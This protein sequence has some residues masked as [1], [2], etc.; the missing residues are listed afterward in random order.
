MP[1]NDLI[2]YAKWADTPYWLAPSYVKGIDDVDLDRGPLIHNSNYVNPETGV[3]KTASEIKEDANLIASGLASSALIEEYTSYMTNDNYHLYT[4]YNN[5][6]GTGA[7]DYM[8]F[9]IIQVG[10]HDGDGSG[11][12]FCSVFGLPD[13]GRM[14]SSDTNA[15]GL[16]SSELRTSMNS[17]TIWGYF[18]S[19][20]REDITTI[21]KKGQKGSKSTDI[22]TSDDKLWLISCSELTGDTRTEY[23]E[24]GGYSY[25]TQVLNF[26]SSSSSMNKFAIRNLAFTRG[27]GSFICAWTRMPM[28]DSGT[29]FFWI[30]VRACF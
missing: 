3:I 12:T 7:N 1:N 16:K 18:N 22:Q 21:T 29:V 8:E 25:Y 28:Y 27:L 19:Q 20:L 24:G 9:R 14:N 26:S 23:Y 30:E 6:T 15:G 17:G 11:L 13:K 4:K 10:Q 5:S 2:L